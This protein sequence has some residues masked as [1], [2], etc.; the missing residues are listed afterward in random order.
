[1][2]AKDA[3]GNGYSGPAKLFS[4]DGQ[5]VTPNAVTLTNG[6]ATIT[7]TLNTAHTVVL[8]AVAAG[9][10]GSSSAITVNPAVTSLTFSAPA[11]ATAG[12]GFPVTLTA[13]DAFGNGYTGPVKLPSSDG[14]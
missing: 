9:V 1:I 6:T 10:G 12:T 4:S 7:V 11:T 14:Q 2:T 5:P 3:F 13:K 8:T